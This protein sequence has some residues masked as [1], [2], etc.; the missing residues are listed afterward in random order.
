MLYSFR[1]LPQ[2]SLLSCTTHVISLHLILWHDSWDH[3]AW[4]H[5]VLVPR[6]FRITS[7]I[8][9][10]CRLCNCQ[11]HMRHFVYN[12]NVIR[13]YAPSP[14][15]PP[16][17]N[18]SLSRVLGHRQSPSVKVVNLPCSSHIDRE[19]SWTICQAGAYMLVF[20]WLVGDQSHLV[21]V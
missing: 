9:L 11:T 1:R 4:S 12:A 3:W 20:Q 5:T 18:M 19:M 16:I 13:I 21:G 7:A 17:N 6:C 8:F 10:F 2:S 14:S 15:L